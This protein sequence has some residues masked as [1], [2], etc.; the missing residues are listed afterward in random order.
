MTVIVT[1][2]DFDLSDLY[3]KLRTP[4]IPPS[5]GAVTVFVGLVREM[6]NDR[7]ITSM[8]LEHYPGMTEKKLETLRDQ[9]MH[10]WPLT[11]VII[12]HRVGK[13]GPNDQI[14]AVGA[15]SA[16]RQ[17]SFDAANFIMDFLKTEAPFWKSENTSDGANWVSARETDNKAKRRW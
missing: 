1:E 10:R 9:A 3:A 8:T 6:N 5:P 13:L 11:G 16:H 12:V 7:P 15:A 14:V 17:A 4:D 2:N